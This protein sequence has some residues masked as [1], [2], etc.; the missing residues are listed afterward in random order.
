MNFH[1]VKRIYF[2]AFSSKPSS[3]GVSMDAVFFYSTSSKE[4]LLK[5]V[6][7]TTAPNIKHF[8]IRFLLKIQGTCTLPFENS[9]SI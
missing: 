3:R 8:N 5:V 4:S 1:T 6:H 2:I 9:L 7:K